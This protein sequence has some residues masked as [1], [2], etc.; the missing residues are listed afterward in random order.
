M[1]GYLDLI[2]AAAGGLYGPLQIR[3]EILGMVHVVSKNPPRRM[4]E[5]G[6]ANGGTLF[7]LARAAAEDAQLI[8][9]DLP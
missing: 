7:L 6:T 9:L 2:L 8:S 1:E 5:I 4:M 3:S